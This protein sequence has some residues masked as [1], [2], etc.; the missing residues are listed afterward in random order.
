MKMNFLPHQDATNDEIVKWIKMI[1]KEKFNETVRRKI[2]YS[3]EIKKQTWKIVSHN[4]YK[5]V[6]DSAE[7]KLFIEDI[8]DAIKQRAEY[9]DFDWIHLSVT[10]GNLINTHKLLQYRDNT[11]LVPSKYFESLCRKTSPHKSFFVRIHA[12]RELLSVNLPDSISFESWPTLQSNLQHSLSQKSQEEFALSLKVHARIMSS[13]SLAFVKECYI[14]LVESLRLY[15]IDAAIGTN[16]SFVQGLNFSN[17]VHNKL[18]KLVHFILAM[19]NEMPKSWA[20]F[21]NSWIEEIINAFMILITMHIHTTTGDALIYPF[22]VIAAL[23]PRAIWCFHWLHGTLGRNI[24]F[25][26]Q[27]K[28]SAFLKFVS[29]S[30]LQYLKHPT[31]SCHSTDFNNKLTSSAIKEGIFIH[32]VSILGIMAC[33]KRGDSFILDY[34]SEQT[35]VVPLQHIL[36]ALI[37]SLN[38]HSCSIPLKKVITE[39][40]IK[41]FHNRG[42]KYIN[43]STVRCLL[44]PLKTL[45]C[46]TTMLPENTIRI[47][48]SITADEHSLHYLLHSTEECRKSVGTLEAVSKCAVE[49]PNDE[50]FQ[51]LIM[52][53]VVSRLE[54]HEKE[55][56]G[57][58]SMLLETCV[59]LMPVSFG[60]AIPSFTS[61]FLT[62][63]IAYYKLSQ[64]GINEGEQTQFGKEIGKFLMLTANSS[65]GLLL[66]L[67]HK[68]II[69][70][71]FQQNINEIP[72]F[73]SYFLSSIIPN[74]CNALDVTV[75]IC[76]LLSQLSWCIEQNDARLWNKKQQQLLN[77]V[78][79]T[80]TTLTGAK[81]ILD[82]PPEKL[83]TVPEDNVFQYKQISELISLEDRTEPWHSLCLW[84]LQGLNANLDICL[85]IETNFRIESKL[86]QL[87][88]EN[89]RAKSD[90]N[91]DLLKPNKLHIVVDKCSLLRHCILS[92][93]YAPSGPNECIAVSCNEIRRTSDDIVAE[94][95]TVPFLDFQRHLPSPESQETNQNEDNSELQRVLQDKGLHDSQW[96][97]QVRRAFKASSEKHING[98]VVHR[99]VGNLSEYYGNTISSIDWG[100]TADHILWPEEQLGIRMTVR[101]GIAVKLLDSQQQHE[102]NLTLMLRA[103]ITRNKFEFQR[104]DWFAA[105]VYILCSGDMER[106][107]QFLGNAANLPCSPLIWPAMAE[108]IG[109]SNINLA[110]CHVLEY[111][112]DREIPEV[113]AAMK[114]SNIPWPQICYSWVAQNFWSILDWAQ[115]CHWLLLCMLYPPEI[116]VYFCV[117]LIHHIQSH[118]LDAAACGEIWNCLKDPPFSKYKV[119]ENVHYMEK[120]LQ[121]YQAD[122]L[123]ELLK[124]TKLSNK[125]V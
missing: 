104:F 29:G 42:D 43:E 15:Y 67:Q 21:K 77:A 33:Y 72:S 64:T 78:F 71:L 1:T 20:R 112:A 95:S 113:C 76:L 109:Y 80:A 102:H 116:I 83:E 49:A 100:S 108:H 48:H 38:A 3:G 124:Y 111:T 97:Q 121:S 94:L 101:Y 88:E 106:C 82:V 65:V 31:Y 13:P 98:T 37:T 40:V 69:T 61:N 24:F 14:N 5:A 123:T 7:V 53:Y 93:L 6:K 27:S 62:T 125:D 103:G 34:F 4:I 60:C 9:S 99:I 57:L 17:P 120:L 56:A 86:L 84:I 18:I 114:M 25:S 70:K 115:I 35:G 10:G 96:L 105:S 81:G 12:L 22:H 47:L 59:A 26:F 32:S 89:A 118:I 87:Q 58:L 41:I 8:A 107:I 79:S 92:R 52:N 110:F 46:E 16:P 19:S 75:E 2:R 30:I 117:S 66:L 11:K 39:T 45:N 23:D 36:I 91:Q 68:D 51:N 73:T 85:H 90:I 50:P 54:R 63:V 119:S 122:S 55:T 28:V 74:I 44:E